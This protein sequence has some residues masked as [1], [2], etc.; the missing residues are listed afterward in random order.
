MLTFIDDFSRKAWVFFLKSKD[1]VFSYFKQWKATIE[2]Q[3][4]EKI[5]RLRTDNGLE[6]C[7]SKFEKFCKKEGIIKHKTVRHTP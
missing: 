3:T 2:K 4:E 1:E 6:L 7:S 5:K